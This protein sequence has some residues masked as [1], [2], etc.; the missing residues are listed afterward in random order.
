MNG[1]TYTL[2]Y[3]EEQVNRML[4]LLG[5][6]PYIQVHDLMSVMLNAGQQ[7]QESL[8]EQKHQ[9]RLS[10]ASKDKKEEPKK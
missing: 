3:T 8:F 7:F 6:A 4:N 1:P 9:E 10:A 5:Q 2:Q